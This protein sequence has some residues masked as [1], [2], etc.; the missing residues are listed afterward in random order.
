MSNFVYC[1]LK[2]DRDI[3][4][5]ETCLMQ[6]QTQIQELIM[7]TSQLKEENA[8]LEAEVKLKTT[9]IENVKLS[10]YHL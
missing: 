1:E 4:E 3:H 7:L 9:E 10:I 2:L 6:N 8:N 5:K